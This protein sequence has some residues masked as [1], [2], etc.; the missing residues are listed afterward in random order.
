M[1]K[2]SF[3]L[4]ITLAY[5]IAGGL[6]I[7]FSDTALHYFVTDDHILTNLQTFKG[8][9]YVLLTAILFYWLLKR[10]LNKL[11]NAEQ[12]ARESEKLKTA[13]LQNMTHEIRTPMN[14]IIGFTDLL[15]SENLT[16]QNRQEYLKM[17]EKSTTR[18]LG[19]VDDIYIFR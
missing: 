18:L 3:E 8:W 10:H 1:N 5:L 15:K 14:G 16:E 4:R 6:W 11:R 19:L 9:F 17:I 2:I 13:F 12:K 7:L